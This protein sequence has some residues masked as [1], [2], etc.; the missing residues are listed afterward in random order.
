MGDA[1]RGPAC[2]SEADVWYYWGNVTDPSPRSVASVLTPAN[3]RIPGR[4]ERAGSD[5]APVDAILAEYEE[6]LSTRTNVHFGYPYNLDIDADELGRF[7]KFSINNLGDPFITSNYGIHSRQFE[8]SVLDFFASTWKIARGDYWG[9]VTTCGTEGNL[10][11]LLVAR[12]VLPDGILY[13]SADSHYSIKK[14]S[15]FFRIPMCTV[16]SLYTGEIDYDALHAELER[17]K[18]RSLAHDG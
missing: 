4:A 6:L 11:G 8:L 17:N 15:R 18:V 1:A 16:P 13:A 3:L 10:H 7:L 14:A 9:Y 2:R 5:M 12:E